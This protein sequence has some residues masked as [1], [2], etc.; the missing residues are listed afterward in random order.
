MATK[1]ANRVEWVNKKVFQDDLKISDI[2]P[3]FKKEDILN[4]E[5]DQTIIILSCL[6]EVFGRIIYKDI[7]S[8]IEK[9][10][11]S[12]LFDV[13]ENHNVQYFCLKMTENW[14]EQLNTV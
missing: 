12:Y 4:K 5:N 7:V 13:T 6:S 11:S 9:K 2:A 8:F 3:L 10:I 14:E 1:V